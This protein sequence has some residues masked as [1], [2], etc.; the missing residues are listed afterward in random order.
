MFHQYHF[1]WEPEDLEL[2][3]VAKEAINNITEVRSLIKYL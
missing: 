2:E 1:G 3:E